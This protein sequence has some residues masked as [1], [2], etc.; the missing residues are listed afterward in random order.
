MKMKWFYRIL[1]NGEMDSARGV[2]F[3]RGR[4]D[5]YHSIVNAYFERYPDRQHSLGDGL[6][7]ATN[8]SQYRKSV[9]V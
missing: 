4:V 7:Q 3:I 9:K 5:V 8:G 6:P 2:L 1:I